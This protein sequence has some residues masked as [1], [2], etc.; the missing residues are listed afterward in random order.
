M[1]T[2]KTY[3]AF[4]SSPD[5]RQISRQFI[6]NLLSSNKAPQNELVTRIMLDFTD[7]LLKV[8]LLDMIHVVKLS[9]FMEKLVHGTVSTIRST[10][11]SVTRT[12][13]HRLDNKQL[14]PLAEYIRRLMLTLPNAA[15]EPMP[16]V[17]FMIDEAFEQRMRKTI[18]GLRTPDYAAH[19]HD[20][21]GVLCEVADRALSVYIV[22]PTELVQLGFI[23]RK[24]ADGGTHVINGAIHLLIRKL[25]PDL[26]QQ[27]FVDMAEYLEQMLV[28][29]PSLES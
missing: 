26:N 13:V 24:V 16:W 5:L 12:V 28:R 10:V 8:F 19:V 11:H 22:E 27:Q 14:R 2:D 9:P 1:S 15:G 3:I 29:N 25:V 17:G 7:E 4:P 20:L 18:K 23:L 6:Q 21:V